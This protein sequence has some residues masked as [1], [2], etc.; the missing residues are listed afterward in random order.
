MGTAATKLLIVNADD[1][2]ITEGATDAIIECHRAG[3]VTS[4]TFMSTMPAAA[5]AAAAARANPGLCVGLH[6]NL[7]LGKPLTRAR[8]LTRPDG[9]LPDRGRLARAVLTGRIRASDIGAELQAQYV[10]MLALGLQPTH[11]DSHQHVHVIPGVFGEVARFAA[12]NGLPLRMPWRWAGRA[13]GKTLKRRLK[14]DVLATT[15][16]ML[17]RRRPK[18]VPTNDGFCSVFDLPIAADRLT[19]E[20][21]RELLAPYRSG[22]IELMVHPAHIDDDLLQKTAITRT[23]DTEARLLTDPAFIALVQELGFEM[24]GFGDVDGAR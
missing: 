8:C 23:S 10:A 17:D 7:T 18:T 11:L 21:Y 19:V 9:R 1:F 24:G 5:H 14:E 13:P 16:R 20:S 15:L 12:A 2:G 4:T 6:F 22:V 3:A